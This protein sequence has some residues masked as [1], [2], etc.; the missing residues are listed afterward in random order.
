[1]NI[2]FRGTVK[3]LFEEKRIA[4]NFCKREFV[5]AIDED[6]NFPQEIMIQAAN[7]KIDLLKGLNVGNKV[8][9]KCSLKSNQSKDGKYFIQ[10]NLWQIENKTNQ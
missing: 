9:A 5:I 7:S 8:I 1:M 3:K 2:E 6:T 4:D 10:L